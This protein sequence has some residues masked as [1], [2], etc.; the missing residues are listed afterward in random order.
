MGS[1]SCPKFLSELADKQ[2]SLTFAHT[3]RLVQPTGQII[4]WIDLQQELPND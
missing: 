1:I 2:L 3:I 4:S